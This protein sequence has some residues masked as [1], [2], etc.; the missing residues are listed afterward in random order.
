MSI[1]FYMDHNV[2]KAIADGLIARGVDCLRAEE[3][4]HDRTPDPE[5]LDHAGSL[6]R[7]VFTTDD[8][9]IAEANRRLAAG[10]WFTGVIYCHQQAATVGKLVRDLELVAGV[11]TYDDLAGAVERLPYPDSPI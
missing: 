10:E 8:D 7:V 11:L 2:P 6:S 1:R 9:F 4:G 5:L 3:D